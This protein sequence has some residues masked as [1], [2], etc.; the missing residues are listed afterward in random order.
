MSANQ[1]LQQKLE[2]G[3]LEPDSIDTFT[4]HQKESSHRVFG[5]KAR[6]LNGPCG[7]DSSGREKFPNGIPVSQAATGDIAAANGHIVPG[8]NGGKQLRQQIRRMLV[9]GVHHPQN[10]RIGMLPSV[11]N[12]A[13]QTALSFADQQSHVRVFD[14]NGGNNLFGPITAIIVY[15]DDLIGNFEWC[16]YGMQGIEQSGK[17]FG[18][19]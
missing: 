15:H 14:G 8:Q 10:R 9:I 12:G 1:N 17:I 6:M 16:E 18:F 3:R 7:P 2:S 19:A 13:G 4:A 11:E 5:A